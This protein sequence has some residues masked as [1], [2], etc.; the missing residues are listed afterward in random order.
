[1]ILAKVCSA[2]FFGSRNM[3]KEAFFTS[4]FV[5]SLSF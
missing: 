3:A 5:F 2:N 1:M 4:S